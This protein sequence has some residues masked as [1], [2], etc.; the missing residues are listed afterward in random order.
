[1]RIS[2]TIQAYN[3]MLT[4]SSE[5][6]QGVYGLRYMKLSR[7][8]K[9]LA[10]AIVSRIAARKLFR[11][12]EL[13]QSKRGVSWET[14]CDAIILVS[15]IKASRNKE[16]KCYIPVLKKIASNKDIYN[17]VGACGYEVVRGLKRGVESGVLR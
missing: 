3:R 4:D 6:N 16:M 10:S 9:I 15:M 14:R 5:S 13:D 12:R 8:D 1:M 17:E 2:K 11:R 7:D